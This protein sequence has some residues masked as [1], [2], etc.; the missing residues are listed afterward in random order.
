MKVNNLELIKPLI[1][2]CNE[3][4]FY[5]L[6]IVHRPKDGLTRFDKEGNKSKQ[7]TIKSYYISNIE[8]L[9]RKMD[10]IEA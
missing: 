7:R 1:N 6:L 9:D 3:G 4:E 10:E 2:N 5:L 8:Y